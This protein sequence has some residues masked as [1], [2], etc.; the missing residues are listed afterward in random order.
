MKFESIGILVVQ[1]EL[2]TSKDIAKDLGKLH[3]I[4][5][6]I[7]QFVFFKHVKKGRKSKKKKKIDT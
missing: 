6:Q 2:R 4:N 1:F 5:I 3:L 7:L